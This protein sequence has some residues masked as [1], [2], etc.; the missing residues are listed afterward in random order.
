MNNFN[1]AYPGNMYPNNM[2]GYAPSGYVQQP[3]AVQKP[4]NVLTPE[5]IKTIRQKGDKFSLGLTEEES[6]RG[7]CFHKDENGMETLRD[8]GDGTV[9]CTICGHTFDPLQNCTQEDIQMYV[10][11]IT[12]VLQT[13]K[14]LYIDMP[15]E[16]AREYFQIIPLIQKVPKLFKIA[17]D[18][19]NRHENYNGYRYNGA[20][21]TIN[22]YQ[23]LSSGAISPGFAQQGYMPQGYPQQ[24]YQQ[25]GF[26]NQGYPQQGYA[27]IQQPYQ[28]QTNGFGGYGTA[29]VQQGY[30]P[31]T[32]GFG[33]TPNQTSLN[34]APVGTLPQTPAS[35]NVAYAQQQ[36]LAAPTPVTPAK[37]ADLPAGAQAPATTTAT[38]DGKEVKVNTSFKS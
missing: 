11:N 24:P 19:F 29:P 2:G 9:T 20:P 3:I 31:V 6:L 26:M 34:N 15:S 17:S 27:P 28:M 8:N 7:I 38:T 10:D 4:K 37:T 16:A 33:Y 23:M 5:E 1:N 14:L 12:D 30:Q 35:N 25:Q 22:L 13:I 21:N 32:T 36:P 18:N